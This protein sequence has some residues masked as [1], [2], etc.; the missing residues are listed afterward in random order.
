MIGAMAAPAMGATS[1][2]LFDRSTFGN[3][4]DATELGTS[5]VELV[6]TISQARPTNEKQAQAFADALQFA[7]ENPIDIG[8]PWIEPT[9]DALVVS[10][11]TPTGRALLATSP[12]AAPRRTRDVKFSFGQL[13]QIK[14]EV[15]TLAAAG[16]PDADLIYRTAPDHK[17]NRVI[18]TASELSQ[19]LLRD[20]AG[21]YGTEAIAVQVDSDHRMV[22]P[23]SRNADTSPFWGGAMISAALG[24]T[25]GFPWLAA[26]GVY[27]MLTAAHCAP[28]GGGVS[29]P[30]ESM[31]TVTASSE[32][33]WS[34]ST[35]THY[36][37]G[38]SVYRGD[39][40][41]IRVYPA[42]ALARR[43]TEAPPAQAHRQS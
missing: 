12:V 5:G 39:V 15:T 34:T 6:A 31:G 7:S 26:S 35:G 27:A 23:A 42:R 14:D 36:Y 33:N 29:T 2:R 25:S 11:A 18:I 10:A 41:L 1:P 4:G 37:T 32:E 43:S 24:C 20:L 40:A 9:T 21:R 16:V 13:E 22:S 8:Y 30:A 19:R 17:N 38:Q 3:L 28:N